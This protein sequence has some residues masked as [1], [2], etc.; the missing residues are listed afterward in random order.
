MER[1]FIMVFAW[2]SSACDVI[3]GLLVR[4]LEEVAWPIWRVIPW[5]L[6][7]LVVLPFFLGGTGVGMTM[8]LR[9]LFGPQGVPFV[10]LPMA[11]GLFV[12]AVILGFLEL[13]A[14]W[15]T[16]SVSARVCRWERELRV[17]RLA[18]PKRARARRSWGLLFS[19]VRLATARASD[20]QPSSD[21]GTISSWAASWKR[22]ADARS[23][24]QRIRTSDELA[25]GLTAWGA[26]GPLLVLLILALIVFEAHAFCVVALPWYACIGPLQRSVL[27]AICFIVTLRILTDYARTSLL[28]P[29]CPPPSTVPS[30]VPASHCLRCSGPKPPRC[31]HCRL[32]GYCVLKMD[33]HCIFVNNCIGLRN[34]RYF[35]LLLLEIVFGCSVLVAALLPQVAAAIY[36]VSGGH[37]AHAVA[38]LLVAL[39]AD[40]LL[41]PLLWFHVGI[42]LRG[43]TTLECL[44][45][46][47]EEREVRLPRRRLHNDEEILGEGDCGSVLENISEVFGAPP[48]ILA[49]LAMRAIGVV[50]RHCL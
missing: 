2:K 5:A 49:C 19:A 41:V 37:R 32:C 14:L 44:K 31:H 10:L 30:V 11:I 50:K 40:V 27:H 18:L 25:L 24:R 34:Y 13:L 8:L 33:H 22:V 6:P 28:H 12:T 17:E 38:A 21:T 35:C 15:L 3:S 47:A 29:G 4:F 1:S 7:T 43:E 45:R 16:I 36:G 20:R 26:L 42:V 23:A 46:E 48:A 39:V 9:V